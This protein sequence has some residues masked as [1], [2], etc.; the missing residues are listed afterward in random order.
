MNAAQILCERSLTYVPSHCLAAFRQET[1]S[2]TGGVL[3]T[4]SRVHVACRGS[5]AGRAASQAERSWGQ[6]VV[7]DS[8]FAGVCSSPESLA[9]VLRLAL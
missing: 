7:G 6:I 3:R 4:G 5:L 9:A 8:T 2:D 1:V